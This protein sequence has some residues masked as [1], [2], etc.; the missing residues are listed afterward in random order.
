LFTIFVNIFY[1]FIYAIMHVFICGAD[2]IN[3]LI[4]LIYYRRSTIL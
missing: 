2:T 4:R 1:S 3:S